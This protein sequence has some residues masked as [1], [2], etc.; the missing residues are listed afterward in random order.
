MA[1]KHKPHSGS[2]AF[3][4]RK[5]AKRIYPK[6][7]SW[8]ELNETKVLGFAGYKAGMTHM[9]V[10]DS[11]KDTS[12]S[13]KEVFT[14]V[15]VIECPPVVPFSVR[16]Y[17]NTPNG[18]K[19]TGEILAS[20]LSKDSTKSLS[21]KIRAPKKPPSEKKLEGDEVTLVV[22]TKPETAVSKKKPE[23]MELPISGSSFEE[24]LNYAKG[25]LGK[26]LRISDIFNDG[27][28]VDV[29]AVTKGK[30][31]QGPV[32]RFGIKI[33]KRKFSR[34]GKARHVGSLGD[35]LSETRW[36]VP[37]A[38]QMGFHTRTEFN[39]W[40]I[41]IGNDGKEITPKGGFVNYGEVKNDYVVLKGSV[42]GP[43]KRL[44]RLRHAIRPHPPAAKPEIVYVSLTSKQGK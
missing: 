13:G 28:Y 22:H 21:R 44:I 38:G 43:S 11:S 2:L 25:L 33:Q 8:P 29:I 23:V 6:V 7:R 26:E 16:V 27:D 37:M 5:R 31:T 12:T 24:K 17:K 10:L 3:S 9:F 36:T 4:P 42:P 15:T 40:L 18:L 32:K 1:R 34:T 30:G 20:S 14:P 35:R 39:K 41:K 19:A